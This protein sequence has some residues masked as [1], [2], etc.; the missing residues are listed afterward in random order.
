MVV[1]FGLARSLCDE[2]DVLLT[3]TQGQLGT[4][5]YMSP[6]HTQGNRGVVDERSD[7]FSLGIILYELLTGV[8][9]FQGS[10]STI[11][12]RIAACE[13]VPLRKIDPR[14]PKDLEA[15]C[16]KA[17]SKLPSRR[18][19]AASDMRDDLRRFLRGETVTAQRWTLLSG[20]GRWCRH[21]RRVREAGYF[22]IGV[23]A[24]MG[25]W[26]GL[27]V[28]VEA[29]LR[30]PKTRKRLKPT[31]AMKRRRR[32]AK[33]RQKQKKERRQWRGES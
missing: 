4:P 21:S 11:I 30:K 15:V 31:A 26:D 9:P 32:E 19:Q 10:V 5:A 29:A 13:P 25:L 16:L 3:T 24:S 2:S 12:E 27:M 1:D 18:Y 22:A 6:E 33:G 23:A 14:I 20:L 17:M 7:V 8:R 28:L